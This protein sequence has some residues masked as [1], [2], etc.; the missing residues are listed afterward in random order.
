MGKMKVLA[1]QTT[2]PS[3]RKGETQTKGTTNN[4]N[5]HH[6]QTRTPYTKTRQNNN[7]WK[8]QAK[9]IALS[10]GSAAM[11]FAGTLNMEAVCAPQPLGDLAKA[12]EEVPRK[13]GRVVLK[14]NTKLKNF[15]QEGPSLPSLPNLP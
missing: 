5:N 1:S 4:R 3:G 8:Q 11:I 2:P 10:T 9:N 14:K 7:T 15:A 6:T 13:K 12:K